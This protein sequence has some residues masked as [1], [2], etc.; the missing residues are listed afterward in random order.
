[1]SYEI[2][3]LEAYS[4]FTFYPST[5]RVFSLLSLMKITS[6]VF[7]ADRFGIE[8]IEFSDK[9]SSTK[10]GKFEYWLG[11]VFNLLR[12]TSNNLKLGNYGRQLGSEVSTLFLNLSN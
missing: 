7:I 12:E 10:A 2:E 3:L 8:V 9:F 4:F 5:G 6:N 1:M 11:T